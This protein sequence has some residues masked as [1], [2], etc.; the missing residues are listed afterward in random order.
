M[1]KKVASPQA[2]PQE[3]ERERDHE[4]ERSLERGRA[5]GREKFW[6]KRERASISPLFSSSYFLYK[7]YFNHLNF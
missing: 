3:R 1:S 5:I 4:R 2:S 6:R 7:K